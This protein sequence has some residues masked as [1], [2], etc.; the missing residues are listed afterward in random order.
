MTKKLLGEDS[1][2]EKQN[3]ERSVVKEGSAKRR[4]KRSEVAKCIVEKEATILGSR[5]QT[6]SDT[7]SGQNNIAVAVHRCGDAAGGGVSNLRVPSAERK[8][9]C[10]VKGLHVTPDANVGPAR[11]SVTTPPPEPLLGPHST[12][13]KRILQMPEKYCVIL[14]TKYG[15]RICVSPQRGT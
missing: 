5:G 15:W 3:G 7:V 1:A 8:I 11:G 10:E 9:H 13:L 2:R 6:V 12:L 14:P 4:A